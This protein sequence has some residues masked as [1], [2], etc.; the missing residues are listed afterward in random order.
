MGLDL[1]E[2]MICI[3]EEFDINI[4]DNDFP[5]EGETEVTVA[6]MIDFVE[7]KI[8]EKETAELMAADYPQKV[9]EQVK[10]ILAA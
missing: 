7:R 8:R 9:F 6:M 4:N 2:F 10:E 5:F 1:A 3:E